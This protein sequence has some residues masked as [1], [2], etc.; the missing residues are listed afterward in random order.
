M[1]IYKQIIKDLEK[2]FNK[3]DILY[4]EK[5]IADYLEKKEAIKKWWQNPTTL[6][7]SKNKFHLVD[8]EDLHR[9]A[10]G[11]TLAEKLNGINDDMAIDM[12][13]KDAKAVIKARNAKMA[14]KLEQSE[15]TNIVDNNIEVNSDGFNGTFQVDTNKGRKWVRIHTI[16]AGGYNIQALHYRTLVKVA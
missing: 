4:K 9:I 6:E 8:W 14:K 15:I 16:I 13:I 5:K 1:T 7:G 12:A 2:V 3:F 10:G 11:K